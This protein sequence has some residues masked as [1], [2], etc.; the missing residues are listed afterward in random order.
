MK[1]LALITALLFP[2]PASAQRQTVCY[3]LGD[4]EIC[5][6]S[7]VDGQIV[8]RQE[9]WRNGKSVTCNVTPWPL[10]QYQPQLPVGSPMIK[11]V[12]YQIPQK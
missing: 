7:D 10:G 5:D 4:L 3:G 2:L 1:R 9:C 11:G 6:T 8:T 12:P